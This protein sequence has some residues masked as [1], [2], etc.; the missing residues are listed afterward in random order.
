[1]HTVRVVVHDPSG[2]LGGG[3]WEEQQVWETKNQEDEMARLH[4]KGDTK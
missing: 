2:P 4:R 1:M 3:H